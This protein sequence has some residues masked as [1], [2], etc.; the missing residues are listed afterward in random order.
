[1]VEMNKRFEQLLAVRKIHGV[2]P[3]KM[4]LNGSIATSSSDPYTAFADKAFLA[5]HIA[6]TEE[7]LR[8]DTN[9]VIARYRN[10]F[11]QLVTIPDGRVEVLYST[12][13]DIK[14]AAIYC[15]C[16]SVEAAKQLYES[17]KKEYFTE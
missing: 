6:L 10:E 1:M 17:L 8:G 3:Q 2:A 13:R 12:I 7:E 5:L 9:D 16:Y 4:I 11:K 14:Y 15:H